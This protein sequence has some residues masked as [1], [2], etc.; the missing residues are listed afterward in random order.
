MNNQQNNFSLADL[1]IKYSGGLITDKKTAE[2]VLIAIAM[3]CTALAVFIMYSTLNS[4]VPVGPA[5][6]V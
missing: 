3:V 1:L 6:D 4:G 5:S 2:Y